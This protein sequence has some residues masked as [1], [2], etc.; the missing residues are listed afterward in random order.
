MLDGAVRLNQLVDQTAKLG[1]G[2]I[3]LTDHG[4]MFG[5]VQMHKLCEG[6]KVKPIVGCEVNITPGHRG[7]PNDARLHHLV[8]LAEN[9]KGYENLVRL[10]SLGWVEGLTPLGQ[11]RIDFELLAKY[12][13]GLVGLSGC[14]GG[15]H[16]RTGRCG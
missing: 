14:M 12:S 9:Q 2:A 16:R 4:N 10:V 11:P 3:A 13:A 6:K 5:T 7:D 1:M 8:L 15:D